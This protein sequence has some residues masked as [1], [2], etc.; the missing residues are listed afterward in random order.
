LGRLWMY[1]FVRQRLAERPLPVQ[2][3]LFARV[4][5]GVLFLCMHTAVGCRVSAVSGEAWS[6]RV[7]RVDHQLQLCV[8]CWVLSKQP[9]LC[10]MRQPFVRRRNHAPDVHCNKRRPLCGVRGASADGQG[11]LGQGLGRRLRLQ[12]RCRQLQKWNQLRGLH[13]AVVCA[14]MAA[15]PVL[16]HGGRA[17]R[18]VCGA[19]GGGGGIVCL[20]RRRGVLA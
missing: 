15:R 16:G 18:G 19:A 10:P 12:L 13:D 3:V 20:D 8:R 11:R 7:V 6:C 17:L 4:R 2:R 5:C 1:L 14:R 9:D